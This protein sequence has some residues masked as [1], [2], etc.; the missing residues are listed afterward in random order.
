MPKNQFSPNIF[1]KTSL[2][3]NFPQHE[4][5]VKILHFYKKFIYA[6]I[7]YSQKIKCLFTKFVIN[8]T[9]VIRKKK[10]APKNGGVNGGIWRDLQNS[11]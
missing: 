9:F 10:I 8:I 11:V 5:K 2:S 6:I 4:N 7:I 1:F 3:T